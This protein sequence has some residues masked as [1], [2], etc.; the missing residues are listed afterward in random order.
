[1]KKFNNDALN[2]QLAITSEI[3]EL[4]KTRGVNVSSLNVD[5]KTISKKKN[6]FNNDDNIVYLEG[7]IKI[8]ISSKLNKDNVYKFNTEETEEE[9]LLDEDYIDR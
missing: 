1:M 9:G 7:E 6:N 2:L 5:L 3:N 8:H 4:L